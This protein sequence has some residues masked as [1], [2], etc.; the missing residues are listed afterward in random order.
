MVRHKLITLHKTTKNGVPIGSLELK[1]AVARTEGC[2]IK[3]QQT[4][5]HH[6]VDGEAELLHTRRARGVGSTRCRRAARVRGRRH[7]ARGEQ[8]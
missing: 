2:K 6:V 7:H 5:Y 1:L 3:M 8:D 4:K